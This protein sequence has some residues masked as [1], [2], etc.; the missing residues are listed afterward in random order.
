MKTLKIAILLLCACPFTVL[1][2]DTVSHNTGNRLHFVFGAEFAIVNPLSF[3]EA[4]VDP[5]KGPT[6]NLPLQFSTGLNVCMKIKNGT[7]C[8]THL[9]TGVLTDVLNAK[10]HLTRSPVDGQNEKL[11]MLFRKHYIDVPILLGHSAQVNEK[12]SVVFQAGVIMS[13]N[14]GN[15]LSYT[16]VGD[17]S[18]A[19]AKWQSDFDSEKG[20]AVEMLYLSYGH[21]WKLNEALLLRYEL[22]WQHRFEEQGYLNQ[23]TDTPFRP[24]DVLGLNI[25]IGWSPRNW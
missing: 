22:Y 9:K 3:E 6:L 1:G 8:F 23:S 25:G 2:Q 11:D 5:T 4:A 12:L 14:V 13:W 15:N 10:V 21:E 19:L 17:W 16:A 7:N 24:F 20:R 18:Q